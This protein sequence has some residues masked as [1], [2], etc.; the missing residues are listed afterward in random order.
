M[1]DDKSPQQAARV[2]AARRIEAL[3]AE[4]ATLVADNAAA[5]GWG[6]AVGARAERIRGIDR[7][8]AALEAHD[9]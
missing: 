2:D 5:G 3:R 9:G 1:S 6:A 4:R 7:E 8:I